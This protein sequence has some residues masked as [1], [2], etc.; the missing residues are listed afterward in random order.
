[1]FRSLKNALWDTD[2]SHQ[3]RYDDECRTNMYTFARFEDRSVTGDSKGQP[4]STFREW[5][6]LH[7]RNIHIKF[8]IEAVLSD[9]ICKVIKLANTSASP[10]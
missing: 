3:A 7:L 1:V 8:T 4:V 6:Q 2:L 5:T 9:L 10:G